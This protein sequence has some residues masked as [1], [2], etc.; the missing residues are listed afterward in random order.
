MEVGI[1][2]DYDYLYDPQQSPDEWP[3]CDCCGQQ[4]YRGESKWTL[5]RITEE[6]TICPDCHWEMERSRETVEIPCNSY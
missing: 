1:N 6:I 3:V 2:P 5:N 4:I